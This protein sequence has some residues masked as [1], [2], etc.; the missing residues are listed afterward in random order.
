VAWRLGRRDPAPEAFG[1]LITHLVS[2]GIDTMHAHRTLRRWAAGD[3]R[4]VTELVVRSLADTDAGPARAR[5]VD[6]LGTLDHPE[7]TDLLVGIATDDDHETARIAAIGALGELRNEQAAGALTRLAFDDGPLGDHAALALDRLVGRGMAPRRGRTRGMRIAQLVLAG[8]VDGELS[9]GGRGDTGGVASL[10]V[11]LGEALARRD[12]VDHVVTIGH[13]TALEAR[14]GPARS[15]DHMPRFGKIAVDTDRDPERSV[16]L[17]E[18]L[19]A[20]ERGVRRQLRLAGR[21]DVLHLRMAD[22]GT[23]AG[24]AVARRAGVPTCFSVAPD[25]HNVLRARQSRGELDADSFLEL[26]AGT[27]VWFRSR[28]VERLTRVADRLALFPGSR[29]AALFHHLGLTSAEAQ[30]RSSVIAEGIDVDLIRRAERRRR[31][32]IGRCPGQDLLGELGTLI[33]PERRHLPLLV[34][35]GRLNPVKGME[36]VVDAW[37]SDARLHVRA[38]LV[39]VG[40]DLTDPSP[41]ERRVLAGIEGILPPGDPRRSGLILLGGRPR[42][43]VATLLTAAVTGSRGHWAAGGIYVDGALKEEFGL[44]VIEALA[45]GLVVVAP[46]T[47]GPPTYVDHG[48]TGILVDPEA[49]LAS[50]IHDAFELVESPGRRERARTMVEERYSIDAMAEQLASLY[51]GRSALT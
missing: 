29:P 36:R 19:P 2:G 51:G 27:D 35:V 20:I 6:L 37:A 39:L 28:L 4:A 14:T 49:D 44:A 43:D 45:A 11:S 46:N 3:P 17:W 32:S 1:S 33:P 48:E 47:G 16:A 5:L 31:T 22:V 40:G 9:H 10:L 12:D 30:G 50:A 34:S 38:N 7:R 23:L 41:T 15:D 25:P 42:A 21:V 18:H 13:G 24:A 8:D 26:E